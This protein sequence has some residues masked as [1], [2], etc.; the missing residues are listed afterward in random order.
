MKRDVQDDLMEV[1]I[2]KC[3]PLQKK[4][5]LKIIHLRNH[6]KILCMCISLNCT[7]AVDL[8]AA[9]SPG[10]GGF[11]SPPLPCAGEK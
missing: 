11:D 1:F 5:A 2:S 7:A 10:E 4:D 8:E 3:I 9:G 6:I